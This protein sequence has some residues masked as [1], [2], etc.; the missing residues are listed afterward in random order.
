[1]GL[2][3]TFEIFYF[4][5]RARKDEYHLAKTKYDLSKKNRMK[6]YPS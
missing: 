2:D 6:A 5:I 3:S 4:L 1:M